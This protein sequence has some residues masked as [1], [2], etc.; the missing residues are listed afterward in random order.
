MRNTTERRQAILELMCER[1]HETISNLAFEF[2]VSERTMRYDVQILSISYPI[3]TATG[4]RNQGGG[5]HV[6]DGYY[7][8]RTYLKPS[9]KAL[10]EKLS[11]SLNVEDLKT[12]Q[13]I[14]NTFSRPETNK[15]GDK[16][17]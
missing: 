10:L 5:V 2:E 16:N 4:N 9:Q 11:K 17:E 7:I 12:M 8:G 3:Y 1:R 14:L 15:R 13:D 6:V